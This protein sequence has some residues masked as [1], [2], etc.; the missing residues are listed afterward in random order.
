MKKLLTTTAIASVALAGAAM[1]EIKVSQL[2]GYVS[3]HTSYHHG[4]ASLMDTIINLAQDFVGSNNI[5]LLEPV[6]QFGTR[7]HGGKDS[8]SPRYIFTHLTK[9]FKDI[10]NE[11]DFHLLEYLNDDGQEIEPK[12]Y[13]P[14]LPMILINGA[15][16]IGTGFSTDVP[17][18]NPDDIKERLLKL[19]DDEDSDIPEMIPWYKG[20]TGKIKKIEENKWTT[21]GTYFVKANTITITELPIGTWTNDYKTF[22]DKLEMDGVIYSYI[23]NSTESRVNFELKCPLETV[24]EWTQNCEIEKKLKLTSHLSAKNMYMFN[25]KNQIVKMESPEEI[26]YHFWRIRNE[27]YIKRKNFLEKKLNNELE[28]I[29]NKLRFVND[30]IA[31]KIVVFK[32]KLMF[33]E[34]QLKNNGYSLINNSYNYLTDMKIHS[35]SEETLETLSSKKNKIE[36]EYTEVQNMILKDFWLEDLD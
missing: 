18:F 14:T 32:K 36:K 13:V 10:F 27:Y 4:E 35:F 7:L 8:S 9:A 11:N 23:N 25:E 34:E 6:G 28:L 2:A 12:F 31:E 19:V 24:I 3:E 29:S 20:F 22:L 16:G 15:C 5:N 30:I 1:S 21:H 17:C 33:I 26:I